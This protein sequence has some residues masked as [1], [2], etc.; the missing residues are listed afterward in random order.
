M[1]DRPYHDSSM[2]GTMASDRIYLPLP[3]PTVA[4][5]TEALRRRR[6]SPNMGAVTIVGGETF[7]MV[8]GRGFSGLDHE[9]GSRKEREHSGVR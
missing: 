9:G 5:W 6:R 3:C 8:D 7:D 4:V 1:S 2:F